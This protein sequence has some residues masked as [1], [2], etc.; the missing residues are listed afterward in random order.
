MAASSRRPRRQR[1]SGLV[2]R[3]FVATGEVVF[4]LANVPLLDGDYEISLGIHSH[5]V[6][7]E[8]D[9]IEGQHRIQVMN[10]SKVMGRVQF[11]LSI[12]HIPD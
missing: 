9:H 8:Y 2:L 5:D 4:D 6:G 3:S 7:E 11:P 10:P 12:R 1:G